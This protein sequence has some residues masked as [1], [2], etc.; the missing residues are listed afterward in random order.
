K[1]IAGCGFL[2]LS[3]IDC[4]KVSCWL[5]NEREERKKPKPIKVKGKAKNYREIAE[6][7][8]VNEKTITYWRKKGAPV[9]AKSVN[10]LSALAKWYA[11]FSARREIGSTTSDHYT[12]ALKNFGNWMV[13]PGRRTAS[14]PFKDLDK[15]NDK[16]E[17]RKQRRA[18][19]P[20]EFSRLIE[21]ATLS[22][23]VFRGLSGD[24][25]ALIYTLAAYTGL[26]A[27][28]IASLKTNSFGFEN[29]PTV[30]VKSQDTKNSKQ[31]ILPLRNDLA[32]QLNF[33]LNNQIRPTL[34]I[35]TAPSVVWQGTWYKKGATMIKRDLKA[36]GIPYADDQ[37]KEYDFHALRHQ[38]ITELS[39]AGVS[40]K[41]A[42]ELARHSKPELT[43][44]VYTHL[45][46]RDTA[47]DVERMPAIPT[48][49]GAQNP[50]GHVA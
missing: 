27:G 31:A 17:L 14:N 38:F 29:S 30:T 8:N 48:K 22:D 28:E 35:G 24:D 43:A 36:A 45:T 7:F 6:A 11:E 25:R 33:Y 50:T 49:L 47:G 5:D 40:L 19:S 15:L 18:L 39:R 12:T 44:N 16:T 46:I 3:D 42:Q 9:I 41:S 32:R 1:A 26:R 37:G 20:L 21:A 2:R 10:D 13:K 4:E 23:W 34:P